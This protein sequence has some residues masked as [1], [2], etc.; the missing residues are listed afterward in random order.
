MPKGYQFIAHYRERDN[1]TQSLEA[2]LRGVAAL[3]REYAQKIG[4]GYCG[5]LLGILHDIGKYSDEFQ[6]Y[7]KSAVGLFNQD[8]DEEFVDAVGIRGKVDH[9]TAGAQLVWRELSQQGE[10]GQIVGQILALCIASHHSGLIDCLTSENDSLGEDRFSRRMN[11]TVERTHLD[12]VLTKIDVSILARSRELLTKPKMVVRAHDALKAI[13]AFS[14]LKKRSSLVFQQQIGLLVRFLFSCLIDADRIDTADFQRPL[15]AAHRKRGRYP[16]WR[17]LIERLEEHLEELEPDHP[18]DHLRRDI[19]NHCRN[20][21]CRAKGI[22]SLTVPTGGGK[23]LASLRFALHH[24]QQYKMDRIIYVL[25]FTTI[26]DQNA[27]AVRNILEVYHANGIRDAVVLEHHSDLTPE[28][29]GWREKI[30]T[31]NWDAPIVYTTSVQFLETLF[32]AGTR[33]ARRMHQ[34]ANAV[35]I[36]DEIQAL[37]IKC[38]HLF[39]NAINFLVQQCGSTVVLCTA[40]QPLLDRVDQAMGAIAIP[41][42]PDGELM[43]DVRGLFQDLRRVEIVN[44]RKA[45]GWTYEEITELAAA[46]VHRANNCLVIVN[47]KEAAQALYKLC[48]QREAFAVHHLSTN[49]CPAHR[50]SVLAK[51][52]KQLCKSERMLCVSTQLIE[53]GVDVDFGSLVRFTAGLDSI[54]QAAGRCNRNGRSSEPGKVHIVNPQDENL[55]MLAEIRIGRD[56]AER[57]LADYELDPAIFDNNPI[58]PKALSKYYEYYFFDRRNEMD[59]PL[60]VKTLGHDDTLLNLLSSNSIATVE[61][62]RRTGQAPRVF[63]RQSFMAAAKAFKAIDAP[64][65]GVLVPYCETGRDLILELCSDLDVEKRNEVLRKAQ[66]YTV[67]VFPYILQRL[68]QERAVHSIRKD[69][70]ILYLDRAYYSNK[71]GLVTEPLGD[72]EIYIV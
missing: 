39:N 3:S 45:G 55:G 7:L 42:P 19:S 17:A 56:L 28:E 2:H 68:Q 11:K 27:D 51:V 33:S 58:G 9:S 69:I 49:M 12:E 65:R 62:G 25:P 1:T 18:I 47:T 20:A 16:P 6:N 44:R 43:P 71:F 70:D 36:F 41:P 59:Y 52:R 32:G 67:N 66:Q 34:L 37:P 35:L 38:I 64:T 31:E 26:I 48:K 60:P 13:M 5:E 24:A 57:V 15:V 4:Q 14:P 29:Q 53:A 8:E 21:S 54:A 61:H 23:T 10:V 72:A 63:L 50:K 22:Y 30:L 40:T 46:E